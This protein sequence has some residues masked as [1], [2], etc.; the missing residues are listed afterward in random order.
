MPKKINVQEPGNDDKYGMIVYLE[1]SEERKARSARE[2]KIAE[3]IKVEEE[4]WTAATEVGGREFFLVLWRKTYLNKKK[5]SQIVGLIL[6]NGCRCYVIPDSRQKGGG[7][8][9]KE[10]TVSSCKF[11]HLRNLTAGRGHAVY[12]V[13]VVIADIAELQLPP[14]KDITMKNLRRTEGKINLPEEFAIEVRK[15]KTYVVTSGKLV[16]KEVK[17]RL[18]KREQGWFT[19]YDENELVILKIL[20]EE[21]IIS[22]ARFIEETEI[23]G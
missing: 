6:L 21:E 1:T 15:G 8:N 3:K 2:A 19:N 4:W 14:K 13:D 16:A 23:K 17:S 22:L 20:Q 12:T 18:E 9:V 11:N 10:G 7:R 5:R